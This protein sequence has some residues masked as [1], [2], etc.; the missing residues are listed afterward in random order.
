M[1]NVVFG[2][3]NSLKLL[4]IKI[5]NTHGKYKRTLIFFEKVIFVYQFVMKQMANNKTKNP[6]CVLS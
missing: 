4:N 6:F 5:K 3:L 1:L 2:L